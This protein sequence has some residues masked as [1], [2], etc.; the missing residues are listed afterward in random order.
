M[1]SAVV[2]FVILFLHSSKLSNV[3]C[4]AVDNRGSAFCVQQKVNTLMFGGKDG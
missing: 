1:L 3:L 2:D 4:I